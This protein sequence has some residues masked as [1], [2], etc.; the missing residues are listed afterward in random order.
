[1]EGVKAKTLFV[2]A[3][4]PTKRKEAAAVPKLTIIKN[5]FEILTI[6]VE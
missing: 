4:S 2:E 3:L 6:L 1:M 5:L